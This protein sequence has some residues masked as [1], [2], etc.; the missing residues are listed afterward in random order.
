[1]LGSV[2]TCPEPRREGAFPASPKSP[3]AVCSLLFLQSYRLQMLCRQPGRSVW[4]AGGWLRAGEPRVGWGRRGDAGLPD[5]TWFL[6]AFPF[7]GSQRDGFLTTLKT[8][9]ARYPS[10]AIGLPGKH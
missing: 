8:T 3:G 2:R 10:D 5:G 6:L 9:P 7:A 4:P 1:M